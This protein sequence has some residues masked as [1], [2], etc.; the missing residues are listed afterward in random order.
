[1][2]DIHYI[3]EPKYDPDRYGR[4]QVKFLRWFFGEQ[5]AKWLDDKVKEKKE[6]SGNTEELNPSK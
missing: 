2:N 6:L 4:E 1:M 3:G 5:E